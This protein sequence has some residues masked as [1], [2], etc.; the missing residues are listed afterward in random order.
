MSSSV[1]SSTRTGAA[2]ILVAASPPAWSQGAK[3]LILLYGDLLPVRLRHPPGNLVSAGC[4][5][6]ARLGA[7][8]VNHFSDLLGYAS[9]DT[10]NSWMQLGRLSILLNVVDSVT[11]IVARNVISCSWLVGRR[12]TS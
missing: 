11:G 2:A 12:M 4:R 6:R 3:P 9:D 5:I 7:H 1:W 8:L 10:S